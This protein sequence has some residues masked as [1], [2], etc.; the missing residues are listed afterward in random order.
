MS[1][2]PALA[3]MG[4]GV[5]AITVVAKLGKAATPKPPYIPE[6]DDVGLPPQVPDEQVEDPDTVDPDSEEP[7]EPA[8]PS[9]PDPGPGPGSVPMFDLLPNPI[10][11]LDLSGKEVW[12]YG[13]EQTIGA[14]G[15]WHVWR[16]DDSLNGMP[17]T[18]ARSIQHPEDWIAF[19]T[20]YD[21]PGSS[22][23]SHS[24]LYKISP[25]SSHQRQKWMLEN[26][27]GL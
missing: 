10:K 4:F 12:S 7:G 13:G 25:V 17:I 26:I 9:N 23:P 20:H 19:F 14:G 15:L 3:L 24:I 27:A 5:L 16:I 11:G 21:P 18:V 1:K 2:G 6:E 22:P 8:E